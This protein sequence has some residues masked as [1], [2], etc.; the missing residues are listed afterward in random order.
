MRKA[1]FI[2]KGTLVCSNTLVGIND[3][4]LNTLL[5]IYPNPTSGLFTV[6]LPGE[7]L[8]NVTDARGR[9]VLQESGVD[10]MM[11]NLEAFESGLYFVQVVQGE[12]SI[13]KKVIKQ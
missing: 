12:N 5:S 3:N 10:I 6:V 9:L 4:P 2:I 11:V 1:V 7:F 13:V 8:M